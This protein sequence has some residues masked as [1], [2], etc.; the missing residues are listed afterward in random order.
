[1]LVHM[2]M[3]LRLNHSDKELNQQYSTFKHRIL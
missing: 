1:M 2:L 3:S